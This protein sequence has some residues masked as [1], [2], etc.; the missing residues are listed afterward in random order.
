LWQPGVVPRGVHIEVLK[1]PP[2]PP[3]L[4]EP[5]TDPPSDALEEEHWRPAAC[6]GNVPSPGLR[7]RNGPIPVGDDVSLGGVVEVWNRGLRRR[8]G[9]QAG[10]AFWFEAATR[11]TN[12]DDYRIGAAIVQLTSR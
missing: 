2:A 5:G 11:I 4:G 6:H 12:I 1:W 9:V 7:R 8:M 3:A 10:D